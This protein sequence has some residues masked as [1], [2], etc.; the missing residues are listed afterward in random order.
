MKPTGTVQA[1]AETFSLLG[2]PTRL[3]ITYALSQQ[4]LCVCDLANV[5]GASQS[6]VSHSLRALRQMRLVRYRREGKIAYYALDDDHIRSLVEEG[7][8]HVEEG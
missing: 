8:R 1:L 3:R 5:L 6:V 2:D 4:E 7:F